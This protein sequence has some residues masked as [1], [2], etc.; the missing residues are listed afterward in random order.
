MSPQ[1]SE[2]CPSQASTLQAPS[3]SDIEEEMGHNAERA[4]EVQQELAQRRALLG[5][6]LRKAQTIQRKKALLVNIIEEEMV[7]QTQISV[8]SQLHLHQ[9]KEIRSQSD[10]MQHLLTLL[11]RQ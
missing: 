8:L 7:H 5:Q 6:E 4:E 2:P 10:E 11:E 1:Q 9:T 3:L